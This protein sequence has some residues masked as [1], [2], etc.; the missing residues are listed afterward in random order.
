MADVA[1]R[2][3]A[4]KAVPRDYTIPGAQ[5]ILPKSVSATMDGS[6]A[7]SAW[8]P[9]LQ[10][11]D[12]GG[13]VMFSA[14]SSTSVAAGASAEVSWFPGVGFLSSS[15]RVGV[16]ASR[17]YSSG[18]Q[19][20]PTSTQTDITFDTIDFDTAGMVNLG[21]NNRI[22][23]C[24]VA[25]YYQVTTNVFW[26]DS[27]LGIRVLHLTLNGYYS[28]ASGTTIAADE[29]PIMSDEPQP[30]TATALVQL[31]AGDFVSS[32]VRQTTGGNLA[33]SGV[34]AANKYSHALSAVLVGV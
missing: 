15:A 28:A 19:L 10:V 21:A 6:A 12:P 3:A 26:L 24:T 11:L 13:N 30:L 18:T 32:G 22:L 7:A 2:A 25:G 14:V 27:Y 31:S 1:I 23:T 20:I 17:I 4:V 34:G 33:T 5:E 16:V 9:C 29:V 8:F